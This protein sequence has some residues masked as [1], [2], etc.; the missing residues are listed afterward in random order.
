MSNFEFL[1]CPRLR[2][3][4]AAIV[5]SICKAVMSAKCSIHSGW[6]LCT[7]VWDRFTHTKRPSSWRKKNL[8]SI[9]R[10]FSAKRRFPQLCSTRLEKELGWRHCQPAK[11]TTNQEWYVAP[12]DKADATTEQTTDG[13]VLIRKALIVSVTK[14]LFL[15]HLFSIFTEIAILHKNFRRHLQTFECLGGCCQAN[16]NLCFFA[17]WTPL[18]LLGGPGLHSFGGVPVHTHPSCGYHVHFVGRNSPHS[19]RMGSARPG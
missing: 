9:W 2:D 13:I 19:G 1:T 14:R 8:M 10:I 12:V 17:Q 7:T 15:M 4:V 18:C 16:W 6:N 5:D 3:R 11:T